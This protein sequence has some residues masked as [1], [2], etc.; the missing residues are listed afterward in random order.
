MGLKSLRQNS[1]ARLSA[2]EALSISASL[3][4]RLKPCPD[5]QERAGSVGM[6]A[7]G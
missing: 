6:S 4:A 1:K 2:A 3:T 7:T 5:T